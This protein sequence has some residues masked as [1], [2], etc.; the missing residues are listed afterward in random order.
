LGEVSAAAVSGVGGG[1]RG[2]AGDMLADRDRYHDENTRE[3]DLVHP[4]DIAHFK[5]HDEIEEE[6]ERIAALNRRAIVAENIPAKFRI[7]Y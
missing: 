6:E 1:V 5:K 7:K 3:E 4:E 2:A